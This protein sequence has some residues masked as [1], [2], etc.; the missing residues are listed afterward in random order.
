MSPMK[1]SQ[2]EDFIMKITARDV[3]TNRRILYQ[4]LSEDVLRKRVA[5]SMYLAG[6]LMKLN[7]D[8][9]GSSCDVGH[10]AKRLIQSNNKSY[11][12]E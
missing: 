6:V 2:P 8:K 3:V 7:E 12:L 5:P 11:S 10:Y 4:M 1:D 9:F